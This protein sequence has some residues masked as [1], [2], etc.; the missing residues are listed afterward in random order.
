MADIFT[1]KKRS[2]VM[3]RIHGKG[4]R[5]TEIELLQIFRDYRIFGWRRQNQIS[6]LRDNSIE[7]SNR[8]YANRKK[9][10]PDFIFPK[11]KLAIFVDGC[12][13][14]SCPIHQSKPNRNSAFWEKKFRSNKRHDRIV[15]K[16]LHENG[17]N[18]L[19]IWEHELLK[20][21]RSRLMKRINRAI[22]SVNFLQLG[23]SRK[24]LNECFTSL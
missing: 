1:I 9:V 5:S 22:G 11:L 12:F 3:S 19:R 10:R 7:S 16:L 24:K 4:N 21:K 15:N 8:K 6:L 23:R 18:V 17:W 20:T 13:W 14:H 2:E